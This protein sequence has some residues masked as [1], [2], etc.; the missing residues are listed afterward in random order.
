MADI[1][2]LTRDEKCTVDAKPSFK[3]LGKYH[4]YLKNKKLKKDVKIRHKI[5]AFYILF[6]PRAGRGFGILSWLVL[7]FQ[8]L[9]RCRSRT[10]R[11]A[12]LIDKY[13]WL[14]ILPCFQY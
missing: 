7:L 13:N 2:E 12:Q 10:R 4:F 14:R 1:I 3:I 8:M 6:Y 5:G 11:C 9:P